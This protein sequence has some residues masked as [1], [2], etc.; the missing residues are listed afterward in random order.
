MTNDHTENWAKFNGPLRVHPANP[1]YFTDN[2]RKAI[3]LTGSHTWATLHDR[4][5]DETPPFDY[6]AWLDFMQQHQHNFL[7]MWAW[8]HAAWMQFTERMVKYSP[9]HYERTGPGDALDGLPKFDLSKFNKKFFSRLRQRVEL[10]AERGIYVSVMFFQG[11][12]LD[13]R[14]IDSV[15]TGNHA[16]GGH[17]LNK[18]NNIN[19]VDGDPDGSGTGLQ[20]HTLDNSEVTALQE[21]YVRKVIDTLNDLDNILWEIANEGHEGSVEW[22][23]HMINV[24]R[25]Y[26][27]GLPKQHLIGMTG[28]PIPNE[29]LFSSPADWISPLSREDYIMDPPAANGDKVIIVD[30]D[31]GVPFGTD[32]SWPWRCFTRGQHFI[33]MDPYK[34]A[35][36]GSPKDPV[37]E[38]G[39]IRKQMGYVRLWAE[40]ID[41]ANMTPHNELARK[42]Y[43]L[44][45]PGTEY[46]VFVP[47]GGGFVVDLSDASGTFD[48][49]WFNPF[50]GQTID[51]DPVEGGASRRFLASFGGHVVLHLRL[52]G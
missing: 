41:L 6:P 42:G 26:E 50:N 30:T 46:L 36:V 8:E 47:N 51:H 4:Q 18:D 27:K 15:A 16:F 33:V 9:N 22:Q 7:R 2:N 28:A 37:E 32:V 24:V 11:F 1:R 31:H 13:K 20:V 17:P 45:N 35:R 10:A 38:W 40:K 5:L 29:P 19:G 48:A 25:E 23:Y 3:Y 52:Q 39:E 49:V 34:D 43:C 14:H 12:S 21:A 44:A